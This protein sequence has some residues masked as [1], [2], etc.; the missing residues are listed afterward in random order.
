MIDSAIFRQTMSHFLSGVTIVTARHPDGRRAGL[1]ASA[2]SSLS[3][4][5]PLILVCVSRHARSLPIIR[6][7]G[8]FAVQIL[9]ADQHREALAFGGA[10]P[11][12]RDRIPMR[13]SGFGTPV[14]DRYLALLECELVSEYP[15][16]DHA[17]LIGGVH[18]CDLRSQE[19]DPLT[20]YRGRLGE[21]SHAVA[22][23]TSN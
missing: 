14:L 11:A 13:I 5:P 22:T 9:R 15:G 6:D 17:I 4:E 10:K 2:F 8:R 21:A 23:A 16:G 18:R 7:A 19:A 1:T 20:Y 12:E 3:L